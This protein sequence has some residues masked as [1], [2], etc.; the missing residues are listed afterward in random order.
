[1]ANVTTVTGRHIWLRTILMHGNERV[2]GI[3]CENCRAYRYGE[4]PDRPVAGCLSEVRIANCGDSRL[5]DHREQE[6]RRRKRVNDAEHEQDLRD[7][8]MVRQVAESSDFEKHLDAMLRKE[9]N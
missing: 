1:M 2:P 8:A 3:I 6:M 7:M 9:L 5:A 4:D